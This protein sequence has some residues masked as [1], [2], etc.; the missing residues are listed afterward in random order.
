[1]TTD[2]FDSEWNSLTSI[3]R[4]AALW[5][6]GSILVLAG[7]GSGKTRVLTSRIARILNDTPNESFRILGLTFTNAAADE[8]RKRIN[9]SVPGNEQRIFIGTFHSFCSDVIRQHGAHIGINPN[10][11]IYSHDSD[12]SEIL[13][14]SIR[15]INPHLNITD[16]ILKNYLSWIQ[17]LKSNLISPEKYRTYFGKTEAE[18]QL[19]EYYQEYE[20]QLSKKNALDFNSLLLKTYELFTQF[21]F[22]A[23]HYRIVYKYICVDE[24]QDTNQSQYEII[25]LLSGSESCNLFVVADDD[26]IIYQW[27][28]AH[29]KRIKT[30]IQDY[31]PEIIQMPM[32]FR[33]PQ[34]VV[35]IANILIK[36]NY[37][38]YQDRKPLESYKNDLE[39]PQ[40]RTFFDLKDN[41]E[42]FFNI[43]QDIKKF[44]NENPSSVA[45]LARRRK[46][47]DDI[48]EV[49]QRE[50]LPAVICKRKDD[51][52]STPF[53]LLNSVLR[54]FNDKENVKYLES[55]CGSFFQIS[56]ID[57]SP[58]TIINN[59]NSQSW[60]FIFAWLKEVENLDIET[61]YRDLKDFIDLLYNGKITHLQ[62]ADRVI[63]WFE[64]IIETQQQMDSETS[65]LFVG[66]V[67]EKDVW[68]K[69]SQIIIDIL[70]TNP[71]VEAFLQE[72]EIHS[73]ESNP[74]KD[75][76]RLM[77]IHGAKG[78]EFSH[79][80]LIGLVEDELPSFQ[81]I[82][83]GDE[84]PEMEEERRNCFVA[85]TRTKTS[86]TLSYAN[87]YYGYPKKPSRFLR[88]MRLIKNK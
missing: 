18:K 10:F 61:P 82:Q 68:R 70:G 81:S 20:R 5:N 66:F 84:S 24:F 54:L 11:L 25:K 8:M 32:N 83:K 41:Q 77:T 26:Q 37:L 86:L 69:L 30:F 36:N 35:E 88:E 51:F 29:P 76:I 31:S 17:R 7:P 15:K 64:K 62:F 63:G 71:S 52:E 42:E 43:V 59:A 80:Y 21:P 67:E 27:N 58:E 50:D 53:I 45:V 55:L 13:C 60:N 1:M 79:V 3:Q 6:E 22:I 23:H 56:G 72:M 49:F 57:I 44:Q 38:R 9:I 4:K 75:A 78:K 74:P 73:K 47:L 16:K 39:I 2:H 34:P 28:G 14:S 85:I 40:I 19:G 46:M 12:L 33:C 48:L 87:K 65:E